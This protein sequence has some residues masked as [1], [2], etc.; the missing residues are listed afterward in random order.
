MRARASP[1]ILV[2]GELKGE[3]KLRW[4]GLGGE[5]VPPRPAV[6]W[7]LPG[8][9]LEPP[10]TNLQGDQAPRWA[11]ITSGVNEM[12]A[13][14]PHRPVCPPRG[15]LPRAQPCRG[16]SLSAIQDG[17]ASPR[18]RIAES[19]WAFATSHA[20]QSVVL[21]EATCLWAESMVA[22]CLQRGAL[23]Q[24]PPWLES[25]G[26]ST[27]AAHHCLAANHIGLQA[28]G[29]SPRGLQGWQGGGGAGAW[30]Q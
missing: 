10:A 25:E 29:W 15:P 23:P 20:L 21:M 28:P 13:A 7:P 5:A 30:T 3:H 17:P 6:V 24:G 18:H 1:R 8:P 22:P 9:A 19:Q 16:S 26:A 27:P 2:S 14:I 11:P 12:V 4:E